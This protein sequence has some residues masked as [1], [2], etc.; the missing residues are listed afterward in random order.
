MTCKPKSALLGGDTRQQQC[1]ARARHTSR[2]LLTPSLHAAL[3]GPQPVLRATLGAAPPVRPGPPAGPP[4][5]VPPPIASMPGMAGPPGPVPPP[6]PSAPWAAGSVPGPVPPPASLLGRRDR[7]EDFHQVPPPKRP[8]LPQGESHL[9]A[10]R[11][12]CDFPLMS[13]LVMMHCCLPAFGSCHD[14]AH[15]WMATDAHA[16]NAVPAAPFERFNPLPSV[17]PPAAPPAFSSGAPAATSAPK[18]VHAESK[19]FS[20]V[21]PSGQV[22]PEVVGASTGHVQQGY[23]YTGA[24][25]ACVTVLCV[26]APSSAADLFKGHVCPT[27]AYEGACLSPGDVAVAA[28]HCSQAQ[29]KCH[30]AATRSSS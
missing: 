26:H 27:A 2:Q 1:L 16:F 3:Q 15:S 22:K 8:N 29:R 5:P 9:P 21:L 4:P 25:W 12:S 24:A 7:Q 17:P 23:Q 18:F 6:R 10:G 28:M 30:A 20:A 13:L 14:G 19:E 11:S